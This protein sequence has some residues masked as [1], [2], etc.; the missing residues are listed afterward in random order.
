M[1]RVLFAEHAERVSGTIRS[2]WPARE[3][4]QVRCASDVIGT[5]L[6][7]RVADERRTLSR[8][9]NPSE[10]SADCYAQ[11][12]DKAAGIVRRKGQVNESQT[13]ALAV[14]K[15]TNKWCQAQQIPPI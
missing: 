1:S 3:A 2:G 12:D 8:V 10:A 5:D 4:A 6:A 9:G 15:K 11:G 14:Q 7:A 13:A